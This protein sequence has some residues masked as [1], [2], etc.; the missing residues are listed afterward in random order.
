MLPYRLLGAVKAVENARLV[1]EFRFGRVH[2]LR[3]FKTVFMFFLLA[4]A[5]A[6]SRNNTPGKSDDAPRAVGYWKH[7]SVAEFIRYTSALVALRQTGINDFLFRKSF[8][9]QIFKKLVP[10]IARETDAE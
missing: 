4:G 1:E 9:A 7:Y 6:R 5:C 3:R 10:R 2:V 8:C